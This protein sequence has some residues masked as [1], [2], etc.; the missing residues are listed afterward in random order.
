MSAAVGTCAMSLYYTVYC[1]VFIRSV[2]G[3]GQENMRRI[4]VN[5]FSHGDMTFILSGHFVPGG[6]QNYTVKEKFIGNQSKSR[7]CHYS[8]TITTNKSK[9]KKL[10]I[11]SLRHKS[12]I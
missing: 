11:A 1:I 4:R 9:K 8:I 12:Q 6:R 10:S 5:L 3:R 2:G 7:R